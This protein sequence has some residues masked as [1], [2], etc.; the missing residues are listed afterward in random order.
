MCTNRTLM[1]RGRE[2]GLGLMDQ[3]CQGEFTNWNVFDAETSSY[4][5]IWRRNNAIKSTARSPAFCFKV[6]RGRCA[7]VRCMG[8]E[9]SLPVRIDN[10]FGL[11]PCCVLVRQV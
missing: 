2:A 8:L 4:A 5:L 6:G 1:E 10:E 3:P 9:F 11:A 7:G